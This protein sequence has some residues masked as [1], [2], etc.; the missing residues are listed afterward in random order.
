M[1]VLL[2]HSFPPGEGVWW[3]AT[4]NQFRNVLSAMLQ[5]SIVLWSYIL[6]FSQVFCLHKRAALPALISGMPSSAS[7][8]LQVGHYQPS[9]GSTHTQ[10]K[11]TQLTWSWLQQVIK[12]LLGLFGEALAND[13]LTFPREVLAYTL[14]S[15]ASWE[16]SQSG[17]KIC[18]PYSPP[19]ATRHP[20][21]R[22]KFA[23]SKSTTMILSFQKDTGHLDLKG[24]KPSVQHSGQTPRKKPKNFLGLQDLHN[25]LRI[26]KPL[27][28]ATAGPAKTPL[29]KGPEQEKASRE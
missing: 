21:R 11:K 4:I 24:N 26:A 5:L 19:K 17:T 15:S 22:L 8:C 18:W 27:Y 9:N 1:S 16:G 29:D 13:L 6:I 7:D 14:L 20:G 28:E 10:G 3:E 2:E 23:D 12:I 25:V